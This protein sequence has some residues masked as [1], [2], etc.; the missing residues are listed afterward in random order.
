MNRKIPLSL[1]LLS[2]L[3]INTVIGV[4]A[5]PE[6][7]VQR[8]IWVDQEGINAYPY[9]DH[10]VFS[11]VTGLWYSFYYDAWA[12]GGTGALLYDVIDTSGIVLMTKILIHNGMVDKGA[13]ED[14]SV[15]INRD[16]YRIYMA[17]ALDSVTAISSLSAFKG[18]IV[19]YYM[20]Y[21]EDSG[22]IDII[23]THAIDRYGDYKVQWVDIEITYDGYMV[24]SYNCDGFAGTDDIGGI[25]FSSSTLAWVDSANTISTDMIYFGET[26]DNPP[27]NGGH[28]LALAP[29]KTNGIAIYWRDYLQISDRIDVACL[30]LGINVTVAGD[31]GYTDAN[32]EVELIEDSFGIPKGTIN[33]A[34]YFDVVNDWSDEQIAVAHSY[35]LGDVNYVNVTL[36]N[37]TDDTVSKYNII[38]FNDGGA[39]TATY[40]LILATNERGSINLLFANSTHKDIWYVVKYNINTK[41]FD[42]PVEVFTTLNPMGNLREIT[43]AQSFVP[44]YGS[45]KAT[46]HALL[47]VGSLSFQWHYLDEGFT[48]PFMSDYINYTRLDNI[49][50]NTLTTYGVIIRPSDRH[51]IETR[52]HEN[53]T[54][55]YAS[56]E[57]FNHYV[58]FNY[59]ITSGQSYTTIT[60]KDNDTALQ[61]A[62]ISKVTLTPDDEWNILTI[63][64]FFTDDCFDYY[65]QTMGYG[66]VYEG[67]WFSTATSTMK[68]SIFNL[69]GIASFTGMG[70]STY[71]PQNDAFS[72]GAYNDGSWSQFSVLYDSLE[73]MHFNV[74][75]DIDGDWN[76]DD[77][78]WENST[79]GFF[80]YG[81]NY[82]L[83]GDYINGWKV[84]IYPASVNVGHQK[85]GSDVD[86][87]QWTV[88]HY[89]YNISISAYQLEVTNTL[90]SNFNG[91]DSEDSDPDHHQKTSVTWWVDLWFSNENA[92]K[93]VATRVNTELFGMYEQGVAWWFGYGGFRPMIGEIT[94]SIFYDN[95]NDA[96]GTIQTVYQNV[97]VVDFWGRVE[98]VTGGDK[99]YI[100]HNYLMKNKELAVGD[101]KGV[102]TPALVK[103]KT[104]DMPQTGFLTPLITMINNIREFIVTGIT[105]V[106]K[107]MG[108]L[109]DTVLVSVGLPP[110][111][112]IFIDFLLGLYE[113]FA[114]IYGS[115]VD[116]ISWIVTSI[117]NMISSIFLIIP[118]YLLLV[119]DVLMVF[120]GFYTNF[121]LLF[122]GGI[123]EM[124]NFWVDYSVGDILQIYLIAVLPFTYLAKWESSKDPLGAIAEDVS[125]F[126]QFIM[127]VFDI[128]MEFLTVAF[129]I[130]KSIIGLI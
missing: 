52:I 115:F 73:H 6:V 11:N 4:S 86:Y 117:E 75:F 104:M 28:M 46:P 31:N 107:G 72:I 96:N 110:L 65:S 111:L 41:L 97:D 82:W 108:T 3:L 66:I 91:Y 58:R 102:D 40:S 76:A 87:V 81:I 42:A 60:R 106:I 70:D 89:T 39:D 126:M 127:A 125:M 55:F 128:A 94:D 54:L 38:T 112:G 63:D 69:G 37:A 78:I 19:C 80:E 2:I 50:D 83:K 36:Y 20:L 59:N 93:T 24:I 22:Q 90:Y 79:G 47:T 119:N 121:V 74:E 57:D 26:S 13:M 71:Y 5:Y 129:D 109:I 120:I 34:N 85:L 29:Y 113:I 8:Q 25:S 18:D 68:Y 114:L 17:I 48:I 12:S 9:Q 105:D 30:F 61:I 49:T 33:S 99:E 98:K 16:G 62:Y 44:T 116:I 123:G 130:I 23:N 15:A 14:F 118:R 124:N 1:A 92:G 77:G 21:N 67:T 122:T 51:I 32:W 64:F 95:V 45:A 101:M 56:F 53:V 84:R 88:E 35:R 103:T 43:S 100:M 27:N 10:M 7:E